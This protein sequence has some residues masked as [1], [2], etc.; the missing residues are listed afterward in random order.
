MKCSRGRTAPG[1]P[2]LV[3]WFMLTCL[4]ELLAKRADALYRHVLQARRKVLGCLH[5]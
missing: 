4:K 3:T 5:I 2:L 1:N